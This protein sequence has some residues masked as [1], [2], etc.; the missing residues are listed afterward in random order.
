MVLVFVSMSA[1]H[2]CRLDISAL[3]S[4]YLQVS[5]PGQAN[6]RQH[7]IV[8]QRAHVTAYPA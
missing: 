1:L 4:A 2:V 6:T 5:L 3:M 7:D 8:S